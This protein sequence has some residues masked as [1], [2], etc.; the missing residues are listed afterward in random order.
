M[1]V[2]AGATRIAA[3]AVFALLAAC[4]SAQPR[5][6]PPALSQ[7]LSK[8]RQMERDLAIHVVPVDGGPALASLNAQVPMNP[9]STMKV[10]TSYAALSSLGPDYRWRTGIHLNGRLEGDV[11]QGDLVIKGG[12]D[13]KFV[14]E[15]LNAL[16]ARIRAKGL[17]VIRGDLL[18]DDSVYDLDGRSVEQFD[19]DPYQPYNVRPFGVLMNFKAVKFVVKPRDGVVDVALDPPL[20]DVEL[21]VA[22]KPAPGRCRWGAGGLSIRVSGTEHKPLIR[23]DGPYSTAC[24]EQSTFVAVLTHRQF[25][26]SLFKAAWLAAGGEWVQGHTEIVRGAAKGVPWLEWVSPRTLTDVVQDINKFSNNVM[27]RQVLL[28]ATTESDRAPATVERARV[29]LR[30]WYGAMNVDLPE[31]IVDNGSGLSREERIS[32]RG[33]AGVLVRIARSPL[34]ETLRLSLPQLGVDG[35]MRK[36]LVGDP[37]AGRAW[38]KT[39]SLD[40]VRTIAGYLDAASGRRYVVV[41]LANGERAAL[42]QPAQDGLLRWVY[43]NG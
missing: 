22:L 40:N 27:T 11:L 14:I 21:D 6:L 18:L 7:M 2:S 9:A 15:D 19:G 20:A 8:Q 13:P 32:A 17:R 5:Q 31:L 39:G 26:H 35:T 3:L 37:L 23:V 25:V 38:M 16:V 29:W 4:A 36:R 41:M 10:L 24:G 12:G 33:M 30:R 42:S 43:A 28:Q 1:T 34:G